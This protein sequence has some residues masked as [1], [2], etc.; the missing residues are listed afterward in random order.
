M[1]ANR[2]D[3]DETKYM[4]S[5][6]KDDEFLKRYSEIWENIKNSIKKESDSETYIQ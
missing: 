4:S 1:R 3:F 6:I 5:L 2:R